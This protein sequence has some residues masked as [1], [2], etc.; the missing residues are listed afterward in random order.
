MGAI[1]KTDSERSKMG[2]SSDRIPDEPIEKQKERENI[3]IACKTGLLVIIA[4]I[5]LIWFTATNEDPQPICKPVAEQKTE[6]ISLPKEGIKSSLTPSVDGEAMLV[7][8]KAEEMERQDYVHAMESLIAA[9]SPEHYVKGEVVLLQQQPKKPFIVKKLSDGNMKISGWV[10]MSIDLQTYEEVWQHNMVKLFEE[11]GAEHAILERHCYPLRD[12][13]DYMAEKQQNCLQELRARSVPIHI[14]APHMFRLNAF[15]EQTKLWK[16]ALFINVGGDKFAAFN[17]T[18]PMV[19]IYTAMIKDHAANMSKCTIHVHLKDQQGNEIKDI[20]LS[21]VEPG[22]PLYIMGDSGA[23]AMVAPEFFGSEHE[24]Y[25][26]VSVSERLFAFSAELKPEELVRVSDITVSVKMPQVSHERITQYAEYLRKAEEAKNKRLTQTETPPPPEP[27]TTLAPQPKPAAPLQPGATQVSLSGLG[28][29]SSQD[30][31]AISA[32]KSLYEQLSPAACLT[33]NLVKLSDNQFFR[34]QKMGSQTEL[35]AWVELKIDPVK[36]ARLAW[37][38]HEHMK[39]LPHKTQTRYPQAVPQGIVGS[40]KRELKG[41]EEGEF[42]DTSKLQTH[43]R[44]DPKLFTNPQALYLCTSGETFTVYDLSAMGHKTP[45]MLEMLRLQRQK[46][47]QYIVRVHLL[48]AHNEEVTTISRLID[49]YSDKFNA[50]LYAG[51]Q[52]QAP[53]MVVLPEFSSFFWGNF[54][55]NATT[56]QLVTYPSRIINISGFINPRDLEEITSVTFSFEW[57]SAL[58]EQEAQNLFKLYT[59]QHL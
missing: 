6:S 1:K 56:S 21:G 3:S 43:Y 51:G 47:Q 28:K 32:V 38:I 54:T 53:N 52:N 9:F 26:R 46:P 57:P 18:H 27:S 8:Q 14:Q 16:Y 24:R 30:S 15:K 36:Y 5:G 40:S 35:S 11:V 44:F 2:G 4:A 17:A 37:L 29:Q 49:L 48:N 50:P 45:Y 41:C 34:L 20:Y 59:E 13:Y 23:Y 12:S 22:G 39:T 33:G 19:D 55:P 25:G 58:T 10:R 42:A 31:A 7:M